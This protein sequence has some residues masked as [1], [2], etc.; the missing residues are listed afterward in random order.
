[1]SQRAILPKTALAFTNHKAWVWIVAGSVTAAP[2]RYMV[3]AIEEDME[4]M[5]R[6]RKCAPILHFGYRVV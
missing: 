4:A 6:I 1:M 3:V 2:G 5:H